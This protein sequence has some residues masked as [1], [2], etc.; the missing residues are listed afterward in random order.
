MEQAAA[1]IWEQVHEG[2]RAFILKRVPDAADTDDILQEVFLRVHR[3]LE[4]LRAPERMLSW[5]FQ[6]T[7]NAIIDHYR[8][9]GRR[10][11]LPAGLGTEVEDEGRNVSSEAD[12]GEEKYELSQCLSPMI[13]RLSTE[14]REAI[15]FVELEGL[16]QQEAAKRLG[17]SLPG[18]KSRVQRGRRQLR[19][20]L[21]DC[22]VIELDN[23]RGVKGYE[24]RR[25]DA[26]AEMPKR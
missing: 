21:E 7:R 12:D 6:I 4:A 16:T 5:V 17:I 11:E 9:A 10:R 26:C 22:C 13:E 18:M 20:M 14:Y 3:R 23:R 8:S 25:P 15:T 1:R 2:L 24:L 19:K